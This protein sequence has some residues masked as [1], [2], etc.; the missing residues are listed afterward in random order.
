MSEDK[1]M[2][3]Q[4]YSEEILGNMTLDEKV[5]E[6]IE[7]LTKKYDEAIQQLCSQLSASREEV[8]RLVRTRNELLADLGMAIDKAESFR[9]RLKEKE[10]EV[11]ELKE[12]LAKYESNA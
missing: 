11:I 5:F 12:R 10:D 2:I 1:I 6:I 7:E 4:E 9:A 8:E 3:A